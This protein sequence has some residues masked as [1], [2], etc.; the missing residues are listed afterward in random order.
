MLGLDR[1]VDL[2]QRHRGD[3]LV[4]RELAVIM[5]SKQV[6]NERLRVGIALDDAPDGES[7]QRR[8]NSPTENTACGSAG[9]PINPSMPRI[10]RDASSCSTTDVTA[11][12][13]TA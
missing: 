8:L 6:G 5:Q 9:T 3:Q 2:G 12:E 4:E 13:S 7:E 1:F 11:V 10:P